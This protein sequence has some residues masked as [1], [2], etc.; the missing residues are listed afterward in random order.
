MPKTKKM[1]NTNVKKNLKN[2]EIG[3]K[4]YEKIS[5][6][7][8]NYIRSNKERYEKV[9]K[10]AKKFIDIRELYN[11]FLPYYFACLE[12]NGK[13]TEFNKKKYDKYLDEFMDKLAFDPKDDPEFENSHKDDLKKDNLG[14]N[15]YERYYYDQIKPYYDNIYSHVLDYYNLD[16]KFMT[17]KSNFSVNDVFNIMYIYHFDQGLGLNIST[18]FNK[19]Y[20]NETINTFKKSKFL[21]QF[22]TINANMALLLSDV[23]AKNNIYDSQNP[24]KYDTHYSDKQIDAYLNY[25]TNPTKIE[26]EFNP[27]IYDICEKENIDRDD[28]LKIKSYLMNLV[29]IYNI[30]PTENYNPTNRALKCLFVD[31]KPVSSFSDDN[32]EAYTEFAKK[33]I[34]G[35][36]AIELV[37]LVEDNSKIIPRIVPVKIK[38]DQK[39]YNR[40]N[41][42]LL[43]RILNFFHV[44]NNIRQIEKIENENFA[45]Q[46]INNEDRYKEIYTRIRK[47]IVEYNSKL[48]REDVH[49]GFECD[50]KELNF[51]FEIK[52][53]ISID[54]LKNQNTIINKVEDI[55]INK[56]KNIEVNK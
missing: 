24:T 50:A 5:S 44:K 8:D 28:M 47:D 21:S 42:T 36:H 33:V 4:R 1:I 15:K 46:Q 10:N 18:K 40:K 19:E 13:K 7:T 38:H 17:R 43:D 14:L 9:C 22:S 30:S 11:I 55:S 53:I 6:Y 29:E 48:K 32:N 45:R 2:F 51:E 27:R 37:E 35:N 20:Y 31:G 12:K 23:L 39:E 49:L 16:L 56:E 34:E 25:L 52:N 41:Y 54:V 3:C 26:L